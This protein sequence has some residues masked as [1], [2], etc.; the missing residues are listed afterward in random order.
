MYTG[1]K[2]PVMECSLSLIVGVLGIA[3]STA[4]FAGGVLA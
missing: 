3:L 2:K 4:L 1:I